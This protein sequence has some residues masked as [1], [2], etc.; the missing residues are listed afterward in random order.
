MEFDGCVIPPSVSVNCAHLHPKF[1]EKSPEQQLKELQEE[2]DEGEVDL[3]LQE[4]KQRRLQARRSPYPSIVVEVRAMP[5]PEFTPPPPSGPEKPCD[6][7]D[8]E[9]PSAADEVE[10]NSDFV[11]QLEALFSK[12]SLE[13]DGDFY[14]NLGSQLE[15]FSSVTPMMMAQNWIAQNDPLFDVTKCAFTVT[16]TMHVDEAHEFVF[17]N[18]AM[19]TSEFLPQASS[20]IETSAQKRQYLVMP[21]FLSNSATSMEK[22]ALSVENIIRTL[23]PVRNKVLINILHPEHIDEAKRSPV[24]VF[25]LQWKEDD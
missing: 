3:N 9:E 25:V 16:D 18:L 21:H 19:Q 5:P 14:A 23:P 24:P 2:E 1:G 7:E 13:K 17:T 12:S 11:N 6:V 22:F 15:T 4:Y 20:S 8:D 10:I